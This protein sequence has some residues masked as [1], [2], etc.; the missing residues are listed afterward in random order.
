M[1]TLYGVARSRATRP[2][3]LLHEI[4]MEFAHVPVVQSYRLADPTAEDAPLNTAS[5]AFLKVNP[6]GQVPAMEEDGLVLTESLA[7][8]LH[9]ARRHGGALGPADWRE[10]AE[11][12]NWALFAATSVESVATGI[13]YTHMDGAQDTPEGQARIAAAVEGLQRPLRRL[14]AH[15]AGRD[16]M[17][18]GRF[19]VADICVAECIRY[20]AVHAP[21][22]A[23][24]RGV[25]AWLARCHAR[26]GYQ[27]MWAMRMAEAA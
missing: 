3:W 6:Q 10:E 12:V 26:A 18:G 20:G 11:A 16:G 15:L 27:K 1:L 13:L 23:P 19:T 7:I 8:C 9:I 2:L 5:E 4:G 17:M 25:A 14:E 24:F 22:L 21:L